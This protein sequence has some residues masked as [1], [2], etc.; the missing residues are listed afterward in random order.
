MAKDCCLSAHL[1]MLLLMLRVLKPEG[2]M[3]L[4]DFRAG[5]VW[6]GPARHTTIPWAAMIAD[7]TVRIE[8]AKL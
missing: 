5:F 3:L 2:R 1:V 8:K 7:V 4:V 6:R